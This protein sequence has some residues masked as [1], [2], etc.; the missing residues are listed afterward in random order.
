MPKKH[1]ETTKLKK[2][3]CDRKCTIYSVCPLYVMGQRSQQR[4]RARIGVLEILQDG[5]RDPPPCVPCVPGSSGWWWRRTGKARSCG[6]MCRPA[7]RGMPH[8]K[9][10]R[11]PNT[12]PRGISM[13]AF[14][15][16]AGTQRR[17]GERTSIAFVGA[18]TWLWNSLF[19]A[20]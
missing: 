14:A 5:S 16:R 7:P 13:P 18:D 10:K 20:H 8:K 12:Q 1:V 6:R 17:G 15:L 19:S 4:A 2:K 3:Q 11:V 9:G